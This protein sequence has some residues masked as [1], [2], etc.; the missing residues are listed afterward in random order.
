M[1]V[2]HRSKV[3]GLILRSGYYLSRVLFCFLFF[4]FNEEHTLE[5]KSL[6]FL[7][8]VFRITRQSKTSNYSRPF[9]K[10]TNFRT[11][12]SGEERNKYH[13]VW[14]FLSFRRAAASSDRCRQ[15]TEELLEE[16]WRGAASVF[17]FLRSSATS[18]LQSR[19]LRFSRCW[20][21]RII[22]QSLAE[23]RTHTY[24][25]PQRFLSCISTPRC[26]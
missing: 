21:G 11:N 10:S 17:S 9:I 4:P 20:L 19:S 24:T 14:F 13:C 12:Q 1:L 5:E 23:G 26:S 3:W 15:P 8:C 18:A 2:P 16:I 6:S 7:K 22:N 25:H